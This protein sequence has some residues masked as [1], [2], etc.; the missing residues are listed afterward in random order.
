[1]TDPCPA[2]ISAAEREQ[3][4]QEEIAALRRKAA[5]GGTVWTRSNLAE[6]IP[7][8]TPMTWSVLQVLLSPSGGFGA[9]YRDLGFSPSA[10][11]GK[12]GVYDL[13]CG[14]TYCNLTRE[15]LMY[16][17]GLRL[18]HSFAA[19]KADPSKAIRPVAEP[20]WSGASLKFWLSLP[21]RLVEAT[22]M[23]TRLERLSQTFGPQFRTELLPSLD[24]AIETEKT[25]DIAAL[26][27]AD[28][29]DRLMYRIQLV[30]VD[31]ARQSLKCTVLA[32]MALTA[33]DTRLRRLLVKESAQSAVN[34]LTMDA[35]PDPSTDVAAAIG[36]LQAGRMTRE[37]FLARF[38]HRGP[39]EMELAEP[40]WS[41]IPSS[42]DRIDRAS[43]PVAAAQDDVAAACGGTG[44]E[45][46]PEKPDPRLILQRGSIER[47][48]LRASEYIGLRETAKHYFM[49]GYA[50]IRE[51]LVELDNRHRL[52]G[53]IFYLAREELPR[54]VGGED[55]SGLI[56][57]RRRRRQA[58]LEIGLPSVI[59]G[60]DLTAIGQ[61]ISV[62]SA[63]AVRCTPLS[64]GLAE[65][66]ALVLGKPDGEVP[67]HHY[68]LVCPSTDPAW[69]PF[70]ANARALVME[71]GGALSHGA[72]V[73][74]EF[75]IPAVAGI[76]DACKRFRTGQRLRVDGSKGNVEIT[77]TNLASS[78]DAR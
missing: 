74:R 68:V 65:G 53:G 64:P 27:F 10:E 75:R 71:T 30:L 15:P 31:F 1:M 44:A 50:L 43:F 20:T 3:I 13:I 61:T 12:E 42:L 35:R 38:G 78:S 5:P 19:L 16:G 48:A 4:R 58:A 37:M 66:D 73:A 33:L 34:E 62:I 46:G 32:D 70:F 2:T 40:R 51:C 59:F 14:R 17:S 18:Q 25:H 49:K 41:E 8:P 72:I 52:D 26:S 24:R 21:R 28:V 60:D 6:I 11:L 54:L 77:S 63:A 23:T 57:E 29:L 39:R 9:M 76:P 69:V 36:E 47:I 67:G 7:E 56:A 22:R 45:R 55:L